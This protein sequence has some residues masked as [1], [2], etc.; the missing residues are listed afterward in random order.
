MPLLEMRG[1]TVDF[2]TLDGTL[3]AVHGADL[4]VE[5][6]EIVGLVGESGCGKSQTC[7][8]IP[9]LVHPS[10]RV[11]ADRLTLEGADLLALSEREMRG[12]RGN[13]VSMIFQE[14]MTSLNPCITIGEQLS[15]PLVLH[16]GMSWGQAR[17]R[18]IE[19]LGQV[20]IPDPSRRVR[21][22]PH[23]LSGGMRQRAMIAMA[24]VCEPRLLIADEPTTALDVTVQAQILTL[25]RRLRDET[26]AAVLLVTHNLGVV[27][28]VC[29]RVTVM[30]AGRMV[31]S[32]PVHPLFARPAHPYTRGLMRSV[33]RLRVP[34]GETHRLEAIPGSVPG[35]WEIPRGCPF[36]PR[37]SFAEAVCS[38]VFPATT[39]PAPGH[40]VACH[41]A[42]RVLREGAA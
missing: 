9:R 6:G 24:L 40:T 14:P 41:F 16:R 12:I 35:L 8:A 27:A 29:D 13:K 17:V 32:A 42:E 31:E 18:V 22:F 4:T 30:Y 33:P 3:R 37:C 20:G 39:E 15:E 2:R 38:Q 25:M 23:Q 28:Q 10:G 34:A 19:V 11:H 7:L 5:P 26:Q 36:H 1:L 21:E